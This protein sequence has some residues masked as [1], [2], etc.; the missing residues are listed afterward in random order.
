[1][2]HQLLRGL[3]PGTTNT[4]SYSDARKRLPLELARELGRTIGRLLGARTP[5]PRTWHGQQIKFVDGTTILV[6]DTPGNHG[7]YPQLGSQKSR[8]GFPIARLVGVMSLANGAMLDFAMRP[9]KG[10]GTREHALF[11]E[12]LKCFSKGHI[13]LADSYYCNHVLITT[14]MAMG[15]DFVFEQHG[16]HVTDF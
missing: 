5:A 4:G 2:V 15:V 10:K 14:L 6:P 9:Y 1:M 12:L 13:M 7:R 8:A 3:E 11:R 16:A